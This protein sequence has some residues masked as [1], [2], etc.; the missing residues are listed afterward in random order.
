[1]LLF[2]IK[3]KLKKTIQGTAQARPLNN[4]HDTLPFLLG[5]KF[6][7]LPTNLINLTFKFF[8]FP[9]SSFSPFSSPLFYDCFF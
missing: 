7:H 2:V 4:D 3:K 1:M 9:S 6:T 5:R 8:P